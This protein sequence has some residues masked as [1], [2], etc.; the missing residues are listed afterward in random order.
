MEPFANEKSGHY[1]GRQ[2]RNTDPNHLGISLD[3]S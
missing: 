2:A 1:L 3:Q